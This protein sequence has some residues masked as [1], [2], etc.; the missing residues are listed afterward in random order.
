MSMMKNMKLNSLLKKAEKLHEQREKGGKADIK[1]EAKVLME[2]AHFYEGNLYNKDYPRA[3]MLA[4]EYFRAA[5]SLEDAEAQHICGQ[6]FLELGQFW[7]SWAHG[8]YGRTEHANFAEWYFKEAFKSLEQ[9]EAGG[10]FMAKRLH[11]LAYIN[12]WGV[13]KNPDEGFRY[14]LDSIKME[15]SWDRATK[16]LEELHLNTPEFFEALIA[17]K[18]DK[19]ISN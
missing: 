11:G 16:I 2:I 8:T 10:S 15:N 5:A 3:E 13:D 17:Y 6:K 7:N 4:L 19:D 12:G 18:S 9:A 14:I 1:D